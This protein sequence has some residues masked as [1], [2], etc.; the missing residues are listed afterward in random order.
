MVRSRLNHV[1]VLATDLEES[2]RF[3]E[4]VLGMQRVPTPNFP[5]RG[6]QWLRCGD[7]QLHLFVRDTDVPAHH[8]FGLWVDDFES[9]Y[10]AVVERDLVREI[11]VH[12][13]PKTLYSL[14]DGAVQMYLHDPAGNL[15]EVNCED[16]E[17][18]PE[19]IREQVVPRSDQVPQTGEAAE[20]VLLFDEFL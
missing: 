18:L 12:D 15:L 2:V 9:V 6:T 16:V 13:E 19:D 4:E 3:Y 17:A 11:D 5:G 8:H 10:R 7:C 20:A 14:P 1:S